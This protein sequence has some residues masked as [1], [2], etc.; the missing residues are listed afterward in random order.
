MDM[1]PSVRSIFKLKHL[2]ICRAGEAAA[3][4]QHLRSVCDDLAAQNA[5]LRSQLAA[6]AEALRGER[7]SSQAELHALRQKVLPPQHYVLL[8][9]GTALF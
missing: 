1:L 7:A 3:A 4:Q 8:S 5:M 6:A 2:I 9:S